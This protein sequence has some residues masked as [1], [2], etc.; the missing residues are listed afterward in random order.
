MR[1]NLVTVLLLNTMAGHEKANQSR[2]LEA[3]N[4]ILT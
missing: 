2:I 4:I 1:F 3:Q